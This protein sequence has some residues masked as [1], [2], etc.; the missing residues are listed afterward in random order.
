VSNGSHTITAV[1]TLTTGGTVTMT[2]NFSVSNTTAATTSTT[3]QPPPSGAD[4][5]G[6]AT[7]TT[8]SIV[9]TNF[10]LNGAITHPGTL[11]QGKLMN[12]RMVNA[13][14][15][16]PCTKPTFNADANTD[17]FIS[18]MSSY[19]AMGVR[20]FTLNL[21]G[22][23]PG[24]E[25]AC[26]SAFHSDGSL[27]QTYLGRVE[28]VIRKADS[29]G[30]VIILGLFYFR[31]DERLRDETAIRTGVV[32]AMKWITARG[33]KNVLVEIANEHSHP[34]YDH[35]ILHDG[36]GIAELIMLAKRT[37]PHIKVSSA[38]P[39]AYLGS[40]IIDAADFLL[41]HGNPYTTAQ[42]VTEIKRLRQYGKPVVVNEDPKGAETV[43]PTVQAG[44]SW[45]YY[46]SAVNQH[47]PFTWNG[48]SE[49]PTVYEA[50]RN[51]TD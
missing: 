10:Y 20:A 11:A 32:N 28:R 23:N 36:A 6:S 1:A 35:H 21:Q 5:D 39:S 47:Y 13:T 29:L 51:V 19:T 12:V 50:I 37:A 25:G 42:Q 17:E 26:N 14:F 18:K 24:Y 45:G 16:D 30:A 15:E 3:V 40:G 38:P 49:S 7:G 2:T 43:L 33:F 48:P 41:M 4:T 31:Q 46:L 34:L 44:A 8:V 9:G 22:G 27:K